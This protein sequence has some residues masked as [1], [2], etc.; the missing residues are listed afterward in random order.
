M[1]NNFTETGN[2][3]RPQS[4][5]KKNSIWLQ[6]LKKITTSRTKRNKI[7]KERRFPRKWLHTETKQPSKDTQ[8]QNDLKEMQDD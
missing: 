7:T 5:L 1:S 6:E 3:Q 2:S 8:T 4:K